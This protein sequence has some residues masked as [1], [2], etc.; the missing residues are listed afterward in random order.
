MTRYVVFLLLILA[1][2][3]G[4]P[5]LGASVYASNDA[6][7]DPATTEASS[8][9]H[10]GAAHGDDDVDPTTWKND[11]AVWTAVVFAILLLVLWLAAWRPI[12]EGLERRESGIAEQIE[13]TSRANDEAKRLL[14]QYQQK[15]GETED[16]VLDMIEQAKV[17][18][19]KSAEMIEKQAFHAAAAEKRRALREVEA[20][21]RKAIEDLTAESVSFAVELA[22][23]MVEAD[24]NPE[25]HV[26]LIERAVEDFSKKKPR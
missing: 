13:K 7:A 4:A 6:N 8:T 11:L 2:T 14:V 16:E 17:E 5:G 9:P 24:V 1:L 26:R 10:G 19:T 18:A 15:I 3:V 20:A 25:R 12:M 21:K 22:G 23:Q